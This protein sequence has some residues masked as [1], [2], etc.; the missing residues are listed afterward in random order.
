MPRREN[1][2]EG[3]QKTQ[4]RSSPSPRGG[5]RGEHFQG[6][7]KDTS[8]PVL[9]ITWT[10]RFGSQ[11]GDIQPAE[12]QQEVVVSYLP[13][14]HIAAQIYDLWTGIQWG[15]QVCFAEPDAL[16]VSLP[17]CPCRYPS[18]CVRTCLSVSSCL[19]ALHV[20]S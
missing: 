16:K 19:W 1:N 15:A 2:L 6:W 20:C 14:S 8:Q 4:Q 11:A 17:P 13:L 3:V 7:L 12:V 18:V 10:A 9:Q 5:H